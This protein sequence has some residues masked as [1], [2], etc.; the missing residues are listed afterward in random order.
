MKELA[1]FIARLAALIAYALFCLV[2][3]VLGL[4][5]V[6]FVG[7]WLLLKLLS[8]ISFIFE[9]L[10][11]VILVTFAICGLIII[12]FAQEEQSSDE[13]AVYYYKADETSA[14]SDDMYYN[15]TTDDETYEDGEESPYTDDEI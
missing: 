13:S 5:L 15:V 1:V 3:F 14:D 7:G 6:Y 4:F 11:S 10:F 9:N 8:I 2:M 12:F